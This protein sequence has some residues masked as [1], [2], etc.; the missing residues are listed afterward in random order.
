M[1]LSLSG[2]KMANVSS[3]ANI[4]KLLSLGQT[5]VLSGI[6]GET[7]YSRKVIHKFVEKDSQF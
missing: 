6:I 1:I 3:L 4:S 5:T 7:Y 2:G